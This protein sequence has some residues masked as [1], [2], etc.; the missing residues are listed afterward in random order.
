MHEAVENLKEAEKDSLTGLYNKK[1]FYRMVQ[2]KLD[3]IDKGEYII[4]ALRSL[5]SII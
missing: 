4:A 1:A 2:E 5:S 3:H